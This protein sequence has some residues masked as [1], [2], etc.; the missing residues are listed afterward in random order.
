MAGFTFMGGMFP[1]LSNH[2]SAFHVWP[3]RD[4]NKTAWGAKL[5]S[6]A[7]LAYP[8]SCTSLSHLLMVQHCRLCLNGCSNPPTA[9]YLASSPTPI[10]SI[11]DIT[12]IKKSISK[13][14]DIQIGL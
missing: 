9:P 8:V 10:D 6:M 14:R 1:T 5:I 2:K 3:L 7:D 4:I 13:T 12:A 11:R